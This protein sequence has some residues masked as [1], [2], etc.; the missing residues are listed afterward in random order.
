[1]KKRKMMKRALL[2]I[3]VLTLSFSPLVSDMDM[4][5]NVS[6]V[7]AATRSLGTEKQLREALKISGTT[8]KLTRDITG[9]REGV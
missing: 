5:G 1:M 2:V 8:V 7:M 3:L 6:T 4:P 9:V